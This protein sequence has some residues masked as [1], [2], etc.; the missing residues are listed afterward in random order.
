MSNVTT[1]SA[2]GKI[3]LFG[4]HSVVYGHPAL[5]IAIDKRAFVTVQRLHAIDKPKIEISALDYDKRVSLPY[6]DENFSLN[7]QPVFVQPLLGI[8]HHFYSKYG[9]SD[10]L[11]IKIH[12][13]IPRGAGLGSSAA[14]CVAFAAALLNSFNKSLSR[15]EISS[16]AFEGEKVV[17]GTPSGIDNTIATFGGSLE[18][19]KGNINHFSG[20]RIQLIIGNTGISRETKVWVSKVRTRYEDFPNMMEYILKSFGALVVTAK[21]E[22]KAGN[23]KKLG[24]LMDINH[25]LLNAI[26]VSIPTLDRFVNAARTSGAYGAKLTG[27]GGGGCM[28]ALVDDESKDSVLQS[29]KREDG[30]P[31]AVN[32]E[33]QGFKIEDE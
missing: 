6:S 14:V 29:I 5:V 11:S 3:I 23:L 19:Q 16:L 30:V 18:Y 22:F 13:E 17:H 32:F 4:E 33:S 2:P 10:S 1:A 27:A 8:V 24:E 15:N 25:G 31:I 9:V 7:G 12:S 20:K 28:I 21:E 26:G